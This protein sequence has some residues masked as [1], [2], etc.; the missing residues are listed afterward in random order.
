MRAHDGKFPKFKHC[1]M[2]VGEPINPP[3]RSGRGLVPRAEVDALSARLSEEL[4]RLLAEA[5]VL[6]DGRPPSASAPERAE[7]A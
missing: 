4:Q 3:A 1:A 6:R 5:Y 7:H 2:V